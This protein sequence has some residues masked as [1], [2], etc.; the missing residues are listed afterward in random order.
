MEVQ[1]LRARRAARAVHSLPGRAV[2]MT[3][4]TIHMTDAWAP[5]IDAGPGHR[6]FHR[7]ASDQGNLVE[8]GTGTPIGGIRRYE[9]LAAVSSRT[10]WPPIMRWTWRIPRNGWSRLCR[11]S[12]TFGCSLGA[13]AR[14]E[15]VFPLSLRLFDGLLA[16]SG[17]YTAAYGFWGLHGR[18]RSIGNSP[19]DYLGGHGAL[20]HPHIA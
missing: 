9:R 4:K 8:S 18:G 13:T 17:I 10:S 11:G 1:G 14:G 2:L 3:S 19:V 20:D 7:H 15:P 6:F 12:L 5:W 16:L